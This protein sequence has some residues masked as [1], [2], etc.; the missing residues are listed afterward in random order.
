MSSASIAF[1]AD[2]GTETVHDGF[3]MG[4]DYE[5]G[6]VALLA[7][8]LHRAHEQTS[9]PRLMCGVQVEWVARGQARR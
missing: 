4:L 8:L 5:A 2:E 6:L 9:E 7:I 3:A 1:S